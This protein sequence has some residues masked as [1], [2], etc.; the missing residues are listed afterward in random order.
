M[1]NHCPVCG[2]VTSLNQPETSM[3][4]SLGPFR[5]CTCKREQE[6]RNAVRVVEEKSDLTWWKRMPRQ[7]NEGEVAHYKPIAAT[8]TRE[9]DEETEVCQLFGKPL[10]VRLDW[11]DPERARYELKQI[12]ALLKDVFARVEGYS[13][14]Q[15]KEAREEQ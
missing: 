13:S 7:K 8:H 1:I 10:Y 3:R 2:G 6:A 4:V 11:R 9:Q 5:I 14:W 15:A 12:D